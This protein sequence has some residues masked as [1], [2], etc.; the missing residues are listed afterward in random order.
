MR[1]QA[2]LLRAMHHMPSGNTGP[3]GKRVTFMRPKTAATT[4]RY[5]ESRIKDKLAAL[6]RLEN[7]M[8]HH[9]ESVAEEI[10]L[11][12]M[13]KE[14]KE[15]AERGGREKGIKLSLSMVLEYAMCDELR[16]VKTLMLR[17]KNIAKFDDDPRHG[18]D[19]TDMVNV[20]CLFASHN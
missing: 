15:F 18:F 10:D 2:E 19:M 12:T 17:D 8:N 6:E 3:A 1:D 7:Q 4:T 16:Q 11:F 5:D 14:A 13:G 9:I 20:E